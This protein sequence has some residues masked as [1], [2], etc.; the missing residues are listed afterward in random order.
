MPRNTSPA[1]RSGSAETQSIVRSER[2][3]LQRS[4][5]NVRKSPRKPAKTRG[6]Y[7]P[8]TKVLRIQQRYLAGQN[9]SEIAREEHC[10]RETVARIVQFPEVRH[11]I[12]EMQQQF[13]GLVPDAMAA[14]RY[15]LQVTKD[16]NVGYRVLEGTGV[17][18][19]R[20]ERLQ[21]PEATSSET[22]VLRQARLV[23]AVLLESHA[24]FGVDLPK[25][26]EEALAKDSRESSEGAKTAQPRLPRRV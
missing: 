16:P 12:G 9:K 22:G 26:M 6:S 10:D 18:P 5:P 3:H 11:F 4:R 25:D 17:A 21:V 14:V 1:V 13:Y 24:N 20:H 8:E 2:P 15:A 19:H 23:A 7:L